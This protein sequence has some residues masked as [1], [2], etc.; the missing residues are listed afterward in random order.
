M[1]K[2]DKY[3]TIVK[4][5]KGELKEL[6]SYG[7]KFV[8]TKGVSGCIYVNKKKGVVI[9]ANYAVNRRKP[10]VAIPTVS[11]TVNGEKILIQPLANVTAKARKKARRLLERN[12]PAKT[13][14]NL[15]E[16][17]DMHDENIAM[18]RNKAVSIDC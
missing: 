4:T 11:V 2:L 8:R 14:H 15:N 18:Y 3:K 16:N 13:Y 9:K 6:K 17:Y 7:F 1:K 10:V 12:L 5:I